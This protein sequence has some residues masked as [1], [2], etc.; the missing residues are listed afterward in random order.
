VNALLE[1][2]RSGPTL[3]LDGGLGTY[4]I[5]RGLGRGAAPES[6]VLERPEEVLDA[7]RAYVGAGSEA[8]H[9]TTFG[10]NPIR[11][12]AAFSGGAPP[13]APPGARGLDGRCERV[14]VEAVRLARESGATFV[15]ADVGPTGEYLPPVGTADEASWR[16]AYRLQARP[17]P[18]PGPTRCTSRR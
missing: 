4:L 18:P 12:A 9:A 14:N 16:A 15:L 13:P 10:A 3:L 1:R 8:V 17:S 2:L 6:W 5:A 11:L 7:H